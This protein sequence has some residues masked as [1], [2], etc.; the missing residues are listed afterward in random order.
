MKK[1]LLIF[2]LTSGFLF[3]S[4]Y[5]L[6][7]SHSNVGFSI[8]HLMISNVKGNFKSFDADLE[9]DEKTKTITKLIATVDT[10]SIDTGIEKRDNHLRSPDFF[11]IQQYPSIKYVMTSMNKEYLIGNLTMHGVTKEV[12]LISTVH[13]V[14]KDMQ[15]NLRVGFTLEGTIKRE[16]FG[17][18]WN[19]MLES[20]GFVVGD[21]VKI[22]IDIEAIEL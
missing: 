5:V 13:G 15:G 9:F 6:D 10:D 11:N 4:E 12:K 14:I 22:T 20:G 7:T 18:T 17:L 19:K 8:K 16:D 1:L 3:A 21:D 2:F